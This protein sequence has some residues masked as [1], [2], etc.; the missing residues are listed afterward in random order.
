MERVA[1]MALKQSKSPLCQAS[2]ARRVTFN[3]A[4]MCLMS[5]SKTSDSKEQCCSPV[6]ANFHIKC[7]TVLLRLQKPIPTSFGLGVEVDPDLLDEQHSRRGQLHPG[8]LEKNGE[9]PSMGS[10]R[11]VIPFI[12]SLLMAEPV[13]QAPAHAHQAA[14]PEAVQITS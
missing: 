10:W 8:D 7:L 1:C 4:M 11:R 2:L 3:I 5:M 6:N 9:E 13:A 12:I 14:V